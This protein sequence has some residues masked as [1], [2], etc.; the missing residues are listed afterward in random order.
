MFV[1]IDE[2]FQSLIEAKETL[3]DPEQKEKYDFWLNSGIA[4]S[5]KEWINFTGK[6]TSVSIHVKIDDK[7]YEDHNRIIF[8]DVSLGDK[9]T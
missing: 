5:W 1:N 2:R 8:L 7:T 3:L 6:N 4:M 9:K